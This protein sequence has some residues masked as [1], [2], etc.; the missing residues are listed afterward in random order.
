MATLFGLSGPTRM[1]TPIPDGQGIVYAT[2]FVSI[3]SLIQLVKGINPSNGHG[4]RTD[5][6]RVSR[7]TK[8]Y[9]VGSS[10]CFKAWLDILVSCFD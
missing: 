5:C 6:S 8:N 10:R 2:F 3:L 9:K 4:N 1:A 7:E